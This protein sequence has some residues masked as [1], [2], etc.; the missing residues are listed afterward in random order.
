MT[1]VFCI[2]ADTII[3]LFVCADV[4]PRGHEVELLR[5]SARQELGRP[6]WGG[7]RAGER[8]QHEDAEARPAE[9]ERAA[10]RRHLMT[11]VPGHRM[12]LRR[13]PEQILRIF[14]T[15]WRR[16]YRACLRACGHVSR[17]RASWS[18]V[19]EFRRRGGPWCGEQ[20]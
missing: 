10:R 17:M 16:C 14:T 19:W 18:S 5:A 9:D 4:G 13:M 7:S 1:C 3:C 15:A 6:P 8:R 20:Q 12:L 2:D 11:Q